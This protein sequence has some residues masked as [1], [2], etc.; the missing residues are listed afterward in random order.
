MPVPTSTQIVMPRRLLLR[1]TVR[2][3]LRDG[4]MDGTFAP[5]EILNDKDLQEWL[6]VSRTPIRDALNELARSGLVEMEPNRYTRV[7]N[8]SE[9]E[10]ILAMQTL[11]VLY[12]GVIQLAVPRMSQRTATSI[13]G[14]IDKFAD[15][16][17]RADHDSIRKLG[18]PTF[19]LYERECGN[20]IL[21]QLCRESVDGLAFKIRAQRV[22]E[23]TN[24]VKLVV[25]LRELAEAT[26]EQDADRAVAASN[27]VFQLAE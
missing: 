19:E 17:E 24:V 5:G 26:R 18:F 7:A 16:I 27:G 25:D 3:R 1:D 20:A 6:G 23:V 2:D 14:G 4:I 9:D 13:A 21:V 10:I 12:A 8:P 15:A 22:L 11:G